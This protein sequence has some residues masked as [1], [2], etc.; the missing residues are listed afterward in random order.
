MYMLTSAPPPNQICS[1]ANDYDQWTI[2]RLFRYHQ[3]PTI[4]NKMP[5]YQPF[6]QQVNYVSRSKQLHKRFTLYPLLSGLCQT[7]YFDTSYIE[8]PQNNIG[9]GKGGANVKDELFGR[10][11]VMVDWYERINVSTIL[12]PIAAFYMLNLDFLL[13]KIIQNLCC[14]LS[15]CTKIK[16]KSLSSFWRFM[17]SEFD[18][19]FTG[20]C[21][22]TS[23]INFRMWI[24]HFICE[25]HVS[26]TKILHVKFW[27][28]SFHMWIRYFIWENVP[29][30]HVKIFLFHVFQMLNDMWIF[31]RVST[32]LCQ[33]HI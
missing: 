31:E 29:I 23:E 14:A 30:S 8:P 15:I 5:W 26:Y 27:T 20:T 33:T 11:H 24:L 16:D 2:R 7:D 32:I 22:F 13:I 1:Y 12:H 9:M 18:I 4:G 19:K 21:F 10:F 25:I 3:L 28:I 17:S 6:L